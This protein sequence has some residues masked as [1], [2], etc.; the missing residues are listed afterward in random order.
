MALTC[1]SALTLTLM[2]SCNE[3]K[4]ATD[5]VAER[6]DSLFTARYSIIENGENIPGGSVYILKGDTVIFEKSYGV[7]D[8]NTGAAIDGNTFST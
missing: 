1:L 6:L 7:A 4:N 8:L 2:Q 5:V 3:K